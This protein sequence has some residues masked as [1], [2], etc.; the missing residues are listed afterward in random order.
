VPLAWATT[1]NNLGS[2]LMRLG[3]RES[4]TGKL[5]AAVLQICLPDEGIAFVSRRSGDNGI[6]AYGRRLRSWRGRSGESRGE[7][8][9]DHEND[10]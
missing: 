6:V 9:A 2:A 7:K 1:Q 5:E 8:Q 3:E 10:Y 4:G